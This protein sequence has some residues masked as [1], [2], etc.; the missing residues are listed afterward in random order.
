[1]WSKDC[2]GDQEGGE[3]VCGFYEEAGVV[4]AF[5]HCGANQSRVSVKAMI[6]R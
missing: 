4:G 3:T 1:M 2:S 6:I 5:S